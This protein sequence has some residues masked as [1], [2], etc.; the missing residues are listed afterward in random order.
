MSNIPEYLYTEQDFNNAPVGTIV[1]DYLERTPGKCEVLWQKLEDGKW[2]SIGGNYYT[3]I[4][5]QKHPV[6]RWG[7]NVYPTNRK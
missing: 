3:N 6:M 4:H 5:G 7:S 2:W 1:N